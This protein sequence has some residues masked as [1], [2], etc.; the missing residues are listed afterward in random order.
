MGSQVAGVLY[1]LA[2]AARYSRCRFRVLQKSILGTTDGECGHCLDIRSF[3]LEILQAFMIA[4][5]A[6][7]GKRAVSVT[8][9]AN[10]Q[11]NLD[12]GTLN[13]CEPFATPSTSHWMGCCDHRAMIADED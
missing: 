13:R 10:F 11:S 4:T 2:M 12:L 9:S 1:A 8:Y 3:L 6:V 5:E 7:R